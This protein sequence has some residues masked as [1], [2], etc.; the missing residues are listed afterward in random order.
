MDPTSVD[1]RQQDLRSDVNRL[2]RTLGQVLREQEG[3]AFFDLV[4]RV[5][6]EVRGVRAGESDAGLR[7]LLEGLDAREAGNL[8]RAFSWYFQLVNLAEE[9]ERVRVLSAGQG[10]R[11]QSLE[12]WLMM[13]S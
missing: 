4:E 1:A 8:A 3:E 12:Q 2:G 10:V 11:P 9:Y 7:A 5:R 6:A 13:F